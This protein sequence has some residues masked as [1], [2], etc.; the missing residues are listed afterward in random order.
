VGDVGLAALAH[1]P[2]VGIGRKMVGRFDAAHVLRAEVSR[3]LC[4]QSPEIKGQDT[5]GRRLENAATTDGDRGGGFHD[6][7]LSGKAF[8]PDRD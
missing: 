3:N 5:G 8:R 1:L 2:A 4:P 7:A 6:I